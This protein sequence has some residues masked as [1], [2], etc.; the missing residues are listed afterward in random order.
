MGEPSVSQRGLYI[1]KLCDITQVDM[2]GITNFGQHR[3][4]DVFAT[5]HVS[6]GSFAD[7]GPLNQFLFGDFPLLKDPPE[8]PIADDH[9]G[10][11][12]VI[13]D[14]VIIISRITVARLE[15]KR[16]I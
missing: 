5:A 14:W 16:K 15:K 11:H 9:A 2:Q 12:P 1:H 13:V 10:S 4:T 8:F 6:E 7:S 3:Q